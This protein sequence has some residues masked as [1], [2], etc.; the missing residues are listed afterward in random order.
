MA[1]AGAKTGIDAQARAWW[2]TMADDRQVAEHL[3]LFSAWLE[4]D[5]RHAA[6]FEQV[7]AEHRPTARP[8]PTTGR[9]LVWGG[10]AATVAVA[11]TLGLGLAWPGDGI[12]VEA[13]QWRQVTAADGS[14]LDFGPAARARLDF[15]TTRR[16]IHLDH[17]VVIVDAAKDASRPLVVTTHH[18]DVRVVGTRFT[19]E[20]GDV[21][22]VVEVSR[23][24]VE[25]ST[26]AGTQVV[27][28]TPGQGARL[29]KS[30]IARHD[31]P[32]PEA[33]RAGWISL[34]HAPLTELTEAVADH[35]GRTIVVM[36]GAAARGAKVSGRFYVADAEATLTLAVRAYGLRRA[37]G[38]LGMVLLY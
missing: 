23:G 36:P 12:R 7:C 33:V 24:R 27:P 15:D 3:A 5:E 38:P 25:V 18:G 30:G 20:A 21:S 22:T 8:R 29:D 10:V 9:T 28:L 26:G 32:E 13:G 34:T 6:A 1:T 31:S 16:T 14:V 19:V 4:Q 2:A 35:S 11:V 37:D 17:G